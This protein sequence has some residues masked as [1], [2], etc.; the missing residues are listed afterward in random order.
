MI[1]RTATGEVDDAPLMTVKPKAVGKKDETARPKAMTPE[2][3][4]EIARKAAVKRWG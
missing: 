2:R 4:A 1:A 3:H